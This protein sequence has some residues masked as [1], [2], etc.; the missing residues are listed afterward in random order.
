M[1]HLFVFIAAFAL[2]M[3]ANAAQIGEDTLTIGKKGSVLNKTLNMGNGKV[4]WN[5]STSKL[6]FSNDAGSSFKNFG[7]GGGGGGGINLLVDFNFDF[8]GGTAGWTVSAGSF[9]AASAGSNLIF[10]AQSGVFNAAATGQFLSS[11]NIAIPEGFKNNNG[12]A[13]CY[14]KTTATDYKLQV[15]DGTNVVGERVISPTSLPTKQSISFI[16]P[17]SGN[18]RLRIASQSDA[19]DLAIDN[20]FLGENNALSLSQANKVGYAKWP[21]TASC[22]WSTTSGSYSDFAADSDCTFPAGANL[23]GD[24]AAPGTKIPGF[25]VANLAPGKYQVAVSGAFYNPNADGAA[26]FVR[27]S[28]GTNASLNEIKLVSTAPFMHGVF[29]GE[30]EYTV[31]QSNVTFR[32]QER[33]DNGTATCQVQN[34]DGDLSFHMYRFPTQSEQAV[35]PET[36]NWIVDAYTAGA[37]FTV[38]HTGTGTFGPEDITTSNA[39]TLTLNTGSG[40]ALQACDA[41]DSTGLSCAGNVKAGI[42]FVVP[43][44][45]KIEVCSYFQYSLGSGGGNATSSVT[46]NKVQ[47]TT[48]SV[49][50]AG[51]STARAAVSGAGASQLGTPMS[52]CETYDI[53]AAGKHTFALQVQGDV[54]SA[55]GG[56]GIISTTPESVRWIARPLTQNVPAPVMVGSVLSPSA[57]YTK[58]GSAL[59]N[60]DGSIAHQTG[61]F[62]TS[63]YH[64]GAGAYEAGFTANV[65]S[66]SVAPDCYLTGIDNG[67]TDTVMWISSN[68]TAS[69]AYK[70]LFGGIATDLPHQ[71]MCIGDK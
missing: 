59:I 62:I 43:A 67:G 65:F 55:I 11:T 68:G 56:Q 12:S 51:V 71:L 14:F 19:A 58:I 26:C 54:V 64:P 40:A 50:K 41:A 7:S 32:L 16:Y 17:S 45:Q 23:S 24:I 44:A 9:T 52:I 48:N 61:S 25:T 28:D 70:I 15:Y 30:F 31:A 20:C 8:E 37:G 13:G 63:V 4:V 57:G 34:I 10:D 22:A 2:T 38:P 60:A 53:T 5:Q 39:A 49:I 3:T 33:N 29:I 35:R 47:N 18:I 6:T 27:M 46:L 66:G 1:K 42:A 21:A 36:I 69:V